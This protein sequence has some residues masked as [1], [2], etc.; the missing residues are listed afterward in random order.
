MGVPR[1]E[2]RGGYINLCK[3]SYGCRVV[4][5]ILE[6][7]KLQDYKSELLKTVRPMHKSAQGYSGG[8]L[9]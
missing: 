1:I 4:Q 7:C 8:S 3:H 5:R 9:L 2:F 6:H